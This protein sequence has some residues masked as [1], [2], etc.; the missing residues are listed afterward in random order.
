MTHMPKISDQNTVYKNLN[1]AQ[2]TEF[3]IKNDEGVLSHNGALVV[4]TGERTGRSPMDRFIV[5]EP[6]TSD[7]IEWGLSLIHI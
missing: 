5:E 4:T 2:L 7:A 1:S 3:A 6:S